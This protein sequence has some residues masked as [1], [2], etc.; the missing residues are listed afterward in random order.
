M[1]IK[2]EVGGNSGYL[3]KVR[4]YFLPSSKE[5][6]ELAFERY[7]TTLGVEITKE[8]ALEHTDDILKGLFEAETEIFAEKNSSI[9]SSALPYYFRE[10]YKRK[11]QRYPETSANLE[12]LER[13]FNECRQDR[14]DIGYFISE[15]SETV[16]PIMDVVSFSQKQS[17]KC[18]VGN[19][20]QNHLQTIF[21]K[22]D[23]PNSQ[24]QQREDGGTIMD[25]VIPSL[26]AY[27]TMPDQ[28]I[29]IECQTTL[30]DRFRLTTGKSTD[31]RIK[32]YLAT[33]T[34]CGL[35][36][37]KDVSDFSIEKVKEIIINN[38]VT[39]VVFDDVKSNIIEKIRTAYDK[40]VSEDATSATAIELQNLLRLS[41][42]KIV[43]YKELINRDIK[44]I[45][46]YWENA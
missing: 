37:Q 38:N 23:I 13:L 34:G 31:A 26:E 15:I 17:A 10:I 36:T 14:V 12:R 39:L 5:M 4:N 44:S 25:F 18:R 8:Y 3:K 43:S 30:K 11:D 2:D 32:R 45:L 33:A 42:N 16:G 22:C 40:A 27:S 41:S 6:A 1:A 19:T 21:E 24:Q 20:L 9:L 29:N 46:V 35:V 28:V 7:Q